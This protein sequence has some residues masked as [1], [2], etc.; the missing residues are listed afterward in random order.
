MYGQLEFEGEHLNGKRHGKGKQYDYH[1][2]LLY[3]DEYLSG[4]RK[5]KGTE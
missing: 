3:E 5:G 2:K 4:K 1:G